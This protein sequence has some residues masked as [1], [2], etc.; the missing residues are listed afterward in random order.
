MCGLSG[1]LTFIMKM[2]SKTLLFFFVIVI[3]IGEG[4]LFYAWDHQLSQR[5]FTQ[6]EESKS[7]NSDLNTKIEEMQSSLDHITDNQTRIQKS[8]DNLTDEIDAVKISTTSQIKDFKHLENDQEEKTKKWIKESLITLSSF[9]NNLGAN[10]K[11]LD[12]LINVRLPQLDKE[13]DVLK[14]QQ[15]EDQVLIQELKTM[16]SSVLEGKIKDLDK[17]LTDLQENTLDVIIKRERPEKI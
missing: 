8:V 1:I 3:F 11:D 7:K 16:N 14:E 2:N 9:E 10:N 5:M 17:R 12:G 4:I 6:E 13:L 15:K